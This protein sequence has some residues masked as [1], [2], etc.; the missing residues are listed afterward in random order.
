MAALLESGADIQA[1]SEFGVTP[2]HLAV[3]PTVTEALLETV[4]V[5]VSAGA[6]RNALDEDGQTPLDKARKSGHPE[7]RRILG[8]DVP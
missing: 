5:L 2:L 4:R 3:G 1:R 6:D 8:E 7:L